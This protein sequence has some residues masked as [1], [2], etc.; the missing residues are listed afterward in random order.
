LRR[1]GLKCDAVAGG[2]GDTNFESK[3]WVVGEG[4][5]GPITILRGDR[6]LRRG[7]HP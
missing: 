4:G 6:G 7:K 2:P 1:R 3:V 5:G